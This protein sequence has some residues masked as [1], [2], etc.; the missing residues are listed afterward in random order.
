MPVGSA[1]A[2]VAE[3]V[4][5]SEGEQTVSILTVVALRTCISLV[6]GVIGSCIGDGM[7]KGPLNCWCCLWCPWPRASS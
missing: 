3:G 7:M 6:I 2:V 4:A 5:E 1:G